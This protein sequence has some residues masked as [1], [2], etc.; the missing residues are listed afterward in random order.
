[1]IKNKNGK[2]YHE[3]HFL[4]DVELIDE[5]RSIVFD[6]NTFGTN[7]QGK[8]FDRTSVSELIRMMI[9]NFVIDYNASDDGNIE[10]MKKLSDF[11]E[12]KA[13]RG[14][15]ALWIQQ[16]NHYTIWIIMSN[17]IV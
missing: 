16:I 7:K 1:M 13:K 17:W 6:Y 15:L 14:E 12:A 9:N 2:V 5:F 4:I 11:R 8:S 3:Q 10:V